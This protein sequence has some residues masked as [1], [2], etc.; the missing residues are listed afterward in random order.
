MGKISA[1][2]SAYYA[3][4]FMH[5]RLLNLYGQKPKPE[6]VVVCQEGSAEERI[7]RSYETIVVITPDIPTIGAA[8]NL[9][10]GQ[11]SGDYLITANTDD[12]IKVGGL[13]RMIDVLD[14]HSEVGLVFSDVDLKHHN[15]VRSWIRYIGNE[16]IV[17]DMYEKLKSR[18]FIGSMP[19]WRRSAMLGRFDEGYQVACDYDMWLNMAKSGTIFWYIP[20]SLGVYELREDSLEH[21]NQEQ[22]RSESRKIRGIRVQ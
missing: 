19:I 3:E 17:P 4:S 7:A 20:E 22:C 16:G 21:R 5:T 6:I 9:A 2:V 15:T 11:A 14:V 10:I 1:L 12:T 18:C 13:A 8:W